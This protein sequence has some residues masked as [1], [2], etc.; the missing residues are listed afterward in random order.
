M[1]SELSIKTRSCQAGRAG[2]QPSMWEPRKRRTVGGGAAEA[3]R[4]VRWPSTT[5]C[6][7]PTDGGMDCLGY[8]LLGRKSQKVD[9]QPS[10]TA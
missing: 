3:Q 6:G 7:Q 8:V 1:L 5:R 9:N 4:T 2:V 10:Q